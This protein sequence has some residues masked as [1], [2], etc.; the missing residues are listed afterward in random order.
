MAFNVNRKEI[1]FYPN[2]KRVI[3]RLFMPGNKK[4]TKSIIKKILNLSESEVKTNLNQ[5]LINFSQRHRNITRIFLK[6]FEELKYIMEEMDVETEQLS[7]EIILL[8]G[9]YFTMEY[10]IESA[11]FFNPSI[12]EDPDQ[13]SLLPGEKRVIVSFRATGEGHISSIAFR[14]GIIDNNNNLFFKD[15]SKLVDIPE[16]IKKHI[17]EKKLFLEKLAEMKLDR[18][19]V[20]TVMG[21]LNENFT[22]GELQEVIDNCK[23]DKQLTPYQKNVCSDIKWLANSHYEITFSLDTALSERV[24]YPISSS[25]K[26]GIEDARFVKF[27]DDNG[28]ITYYGTYTAYNGETILPK[29][30]ETEDFYHFKIMPINGKYAQNKGIA[31]FPKRINGKYVMLSRTDGINNYIMMSDDIHLWQKAELIQEPLYP[32][33]FIQVGNCG[34]PIETDQG[35]LLL[36]H[37]VGPMRRYCIGAV[38]LDLNDPT[39][40]LAQTSEPLL[41][42]NDEEREGYVPNVV[43]SCGGMVHNNEL[44]IPYAMADYSSTFAT[45]PLD[46]LFENMTY[47]YS[48]EKY[49]PF[50]IVK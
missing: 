30:I 48:V 39:K 32:W 37:G 5:I 13:S 29:L 6:H 4:R 17:Y 35:W 20:E 25:E 41:S 16:A 42:P 40:V 14:S 49:K 10:S 36:T 23:K 46:E 18:A 45:I 8:I 26:N 50:F 19:V 27:T 12:I 7:N 34:S 11:A 9:A 15:T 47:N 33:E 44:I 22:Y 24:I 3:A 21:S 2:S 38:L 28:K 43:Y 1:R 31:L